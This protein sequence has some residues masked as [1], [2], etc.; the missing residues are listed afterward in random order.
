MNEDFGRADRKREPGDLSLFISSGD[1]GLLSRLRRDQGA[2]CT[3]AWAGGGEYPPEP[4]HF[5][6]GGVTPLFYSVQVLLYEKKEGNAPG[7]VADDAVYRNRVID[8]E[9]YYK[10]LFSAGKAYR[11]A[12]VKIS[13][14]V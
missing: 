12:G 8:G 14:D 2:S 7:C 4:A 1:R 11:P 3:A 5:I 6:S 10:E 13:P 9:F